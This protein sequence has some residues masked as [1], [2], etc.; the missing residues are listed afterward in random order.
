MP[1]DEARWLGVESIAPMNC[2]GWW[3]TYASEKYE[4]QL[5]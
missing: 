4:S 1:E 2:T 5:G 3:Y